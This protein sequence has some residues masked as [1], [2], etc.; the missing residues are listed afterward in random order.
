MNEL[1]IDGWEGRHGTRRD[2]TV[3]DGTGRD[4]RDGRAT[5]KKRKQ[6]QKKGGSGQAKRNGREE[7]EEGGQGGYKKVIG[8]GRCKEVVKWIKEGKGRR[9]G[10]RKG[11]KSAR[12]GGVSMYSER[13]VRGRGKS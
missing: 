3:R 6:R 9:K 7:G 10:K 5:A 11:K 2:E 4:T 12:V 13:H 1:R 8:K